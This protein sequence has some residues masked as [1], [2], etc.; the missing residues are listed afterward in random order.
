MTSSLST[1][2]TQSSDF[3]PPKLS[4][5]GERREPISGIVSQTSAAAAASGRFVK[6]CFESVR[7]SSAGDDGWTRVYTP[8]CVLCFCYVHAPVKIV[9]DTLTV[10]I[11]NKE[12]RYNHGGLSGRH[13][14]LDQLLRDVSTFNS[15]FFS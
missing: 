6:P 8:S 15:L 13:Y 11:S 3:L 5:L 10:I 12:I 9:V 2:T 7:E 1:W 14:G 4:A